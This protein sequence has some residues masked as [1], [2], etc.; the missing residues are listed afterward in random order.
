MQY[1]KDQKITKN[2]VLPI[3]IAYKPDKIKSISSLLAE[4]HGVD[5]KTDKG[6][7][8]SCNVFKMTKR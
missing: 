8:L 2:Q 7:Y 1:K 5:W 3:S 4:H 6:L